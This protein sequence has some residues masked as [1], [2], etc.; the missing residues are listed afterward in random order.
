M[1]WIV[2]KEEKGFIKLISKSN[3]DRM[4]PKGAYLTVKDRD[5]Q[6]KEIKFILRVE[7]TESWAEYEPSPLIAEHNIEGIPADRACRNIVTAYRVKTIEDTDD[8]GIAYIHPQTEAD[9]STQEE[10]DQAMGVDP[11]NKKGPEVF[12]ATVFNDD[13]KILRDKNKQ[14][15]KANLPEEFYYYQTMICGKTGSGKTV[16][17]K[18]L[19]Q[20]FVE[21]MGGAVLAINVKQDDLLRMNEATN[22]SDGN[23]AVAEEWRMLG[24]Q[25]H[26]VK[27]FTVYYPAQSMPNNYAHL[28]KDNLE[29]ITLNIA[30]IEPE[31]L[32][33]ALEDVTDKAASSLPGIFKKW[34]DDNDKKKGEYRLNDFLNYIKKH[35]EDRNFPTVD[36]YGNESFTIL[37]PGTFNNIIFSLNNA[38]KYFDNPGS[39]MLEADD[40]LVRHKMSVIDV[41][42][43]VK[44][45]SL[46]LR[47]LLKR[48]IK[49]KYEGSSS[50]PLL[51]I[52][53]EVHQFYRDDTSAAALDDLNTICRTG[54][55]KEI[56]VFFASQNPQDMPHGIA[57]VVNTKIYLK[58]DGQSAK[59]IPT[60]LTAEEIEGL[61]KGYAIAS[62]HELSKLRVLKF[63]VAFA[64][65]MKNGS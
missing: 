49:S 46:V 18:Y 4:V 38:Q 39:R 36:K 32:V 61:K 2:L 63:P 34:R 60:R 19:A 52:I 62:I 30:T 25:P 9:W 29:P 28:A 14:M 42:N 40:I 23:D 22:I 10:I 26:G 53:D 35:D 8:Q 45:G 20:Y 11:T 24:E 59:D 6:G 27:M 48:L 7:G 43:D 65:V 16:A 21:K 37:H 56:G 47:D 51:I 33:G 17:M 12:V 55:Q 44:F 3:S 57:S 58:T 5:A 64:G 41:A 1:T 15:I 31:A 13:N 54:R 50:V